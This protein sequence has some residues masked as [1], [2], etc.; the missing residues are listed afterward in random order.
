[1]LLNAEREGENSK[2]RMDGVGEFVC[3]DGK[4]GDV[5]RSW[6]ERKKGWEVTIRR[7]FKEW[8]MLRVCCGRSGWYQLY[9]LAVGVVRDNLDWGGFLWYEGMG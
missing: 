3:S 9:F 2:V 7:E 6:D 5:E 8:W 1:M 4:N